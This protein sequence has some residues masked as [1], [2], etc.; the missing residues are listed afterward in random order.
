MEGSRDDPEFVRACGVVKGLED[1]YGRD[2]YVL[3]PVGDFDVRLVSRR[4]D[5]SSEGGKAS[6]RQKAQAA[7]RRQCSER[8]K[9]ALWRA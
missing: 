9:P 1:L 8:G 2:R 4:L 6:T 5:S 3:H 7:P